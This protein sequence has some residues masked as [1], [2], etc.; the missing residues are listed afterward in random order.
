MARRGSV[1]ATTALL[2]AVALAAGGCGVAQ[3]GRDVAQ[4]TAV[5]VVAAMGAEGQ[6]LAALGFDPAELD[7]EAAAPTPS[8]SAEGRTRQERVE[9]LRKR[10]AARVLLRK[11]TLHGEAVVQTRD[12]GTKTIAVQRGEVTAL[13]GDTMTVKSTDGFTQTWTLA[14]DLRVIERRKSIAATDVKVGTKL[15]VA[16]A[17][18]GDQA[19][20][21]LI[22][23]P[24]DGN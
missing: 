16:G 14:D 4:E 13:D 6:A 22:V 9:E 17:K 11:N 12:G 21:R 19:S 2:V 8:E 24:L 3:P 15:G 7:P 20:A 5:E 10:R 18:D 23:I 1:T